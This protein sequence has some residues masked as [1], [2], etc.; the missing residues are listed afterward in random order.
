MGQGI[1]ANLA[2]V[3]TEGHK[4]FVQILAKQYGDRR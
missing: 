1:F 3:I 2:S 4:R